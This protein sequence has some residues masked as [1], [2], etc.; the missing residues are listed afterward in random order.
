MPIVRTFAP[1]VAGIGKMSYPRFAVYNVA[2]GAVWVLSFLMAGWWFGGL[3]TVQ[4]NFHLVIGAIIVISVLPPI[5]E[6]LRLRLGESKSGGGPGAGSL[7]APEPME[8]ETRPK[9]AALPEP[10]ASEEVKG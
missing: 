10:V 1:F 8:E 2:G 5:I 9:G 7:S 3:E 4:K 6:A